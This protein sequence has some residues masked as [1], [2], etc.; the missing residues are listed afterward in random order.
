MLFQ[1]SAL[2]GSM[3][4][5]ENVA[6]PLTEFTDLAGPVIDRVVRMKLAMV[7]LSGYEDHL[8]S[9]LSGGMRKGQ[10]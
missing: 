2:L 3:T 8:P 10:A 1:S 5:A 9:E 4:L 7:G 6:L